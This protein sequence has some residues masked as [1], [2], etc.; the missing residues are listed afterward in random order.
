MQ[1]ECVPDYV[2]TEWGLIT[3]WHRAGNPSRTRSEL[4]GSCMGRLSRQ[5]ETTDNPKIYKR[6]K[7]ERD[8]G[9]SYCPPNRRENAN[10]YTYKRKKKEYQLPPS[11]RWFGVVTW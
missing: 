5:I 3:S 11:K 1:W 4:V 7:R 10:S 8:T 9:C 2:L 6:L